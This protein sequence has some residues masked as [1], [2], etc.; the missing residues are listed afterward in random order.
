MVCK[1]SQSGKIFTY[2]TFSEIEAFYRISDIQF[3]E[4]P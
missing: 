2:F 4:F 3:S 1:N